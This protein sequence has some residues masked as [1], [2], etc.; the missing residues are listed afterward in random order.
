MSTVK[1]FVHALRNVGPIK[2]GLRVGGEVAKDNVLTNAAAMAYAWVFAVFPLIIFFMTLVPY[3]PHEFKEKTPDYVA[4]V[5]YRAGMTWA[6]VDPVQ[7]LV[8]S[9]LTNTHG[10]L[11]SIGLVLTLYAASGGM[12]TTMAGLDAAL[13]V[14][15]PRSFWL[16][17]LIAMALTVFLGVA[18]IIVIVL[19]PLGGFL[20]RLLTDYAH[21]LPAGVQ[22]WMTTKTVILTTIIRYVVSLTVLQLMIGVL[23]TF[24][25]SRRQPFRVFSPGSL[26]TMFGWILTGSALRYYFEHFG[27]FSK[28]YGSVLGVAVMLTVFYLDATI[29]LIGAEFDNEIAKA[30]YE[31]TPKA[32]APVPSPGT[33]G[34]G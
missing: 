32:D 23:Y 22:A 7:Q 2:L 29:I 24:G 12:N 5:M 10:G 19:L 17:R 33:P 25:P 27:N 4:D 6:I 9:L 14:D 20:T 34:E 30:R 11:L 28:T 16:K 18:F 8:K 21:Y 31:D 13:D 3:L 26:F 1:D 15:K